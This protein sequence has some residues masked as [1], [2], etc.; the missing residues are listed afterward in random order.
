MSKL[1]DL[2]A[3]QCFLNAPLMLK[4]E[5]PVKRGNKSLSSLHLHKHIYPSGAK[6]GISCENYVYTMAADALSPC[7][8]RSPTANF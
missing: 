2:G 6:I 3:H 8:T 7:I 5:H 4:L 1:L